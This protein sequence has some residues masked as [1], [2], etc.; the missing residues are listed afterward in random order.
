MLTLTI[1]APCEPLS[2]NQRVHW[3]VKAKRTA[4]WRARAHVAA[5][6]AGRPKLERA[7]VTV[8]VHSTTN[9]RRDVLNLADTAK[10]CLDGIVSDA[11]VLPDDSDAYVVGPDLRPGPKAD[12][13]T[14][15]VALDD[16]CECRDCRARWSA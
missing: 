15:T 8:T 2:S 14:L 13:L 5:I 3:R 10:A 11:H 6:Q 7:H 9:R 12:V 1:P 16:A 4:A